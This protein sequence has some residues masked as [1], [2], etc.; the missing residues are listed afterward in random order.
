ME[1]KGVYTESSKLS[2]ETLR[3]NHC[4]GGGGCFFPSLSSLV[5]Q[6]KSW[7]GGLGPW[8]AFFEVSRG[9]LRQGECNNMV[10][11][12]KRVRV[13]KIKKRK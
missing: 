2:T 3:V 5:R 9:W 8:K 6:I 7:R 4:R 1:C 12:V 11:E 13:S 10:K